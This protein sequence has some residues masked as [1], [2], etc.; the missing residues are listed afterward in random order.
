MQ[1]YK[2]SDINI[3]E[4][5]NDSGFGDAFWDIIPEAWPMNERIDKPDFIQIK[6]ALLKTVSREL[7]DKPQTRRKYFQKT[8][9]NEDLPK[10]CKLFLKLNKKNNQQHD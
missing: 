5:T 9:L 8:H 7:E 3:G 1:N 2:T 10:I 4:N 6:T